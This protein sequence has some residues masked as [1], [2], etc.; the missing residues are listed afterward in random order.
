MKVMALHSLPPVAPANGRHVWEFDLSA[1]A[2][3]IREVMPDAIVA[4]VRGE[5]DEVL[6]VL[7]KDRPDVVFNLCEAPLGRPDREP[8]AAAL[9]EWLGIRFTGSRSETLAL[10]RRKDRVNAALLAAGVPVPRSGVFP[11]IVKPSDEHSSAGLDHDSICEDAA[12]VAAAAARWK[13]PV[14][15]QEFL[16]GREFA[17]A[18]WGRTSPDHFS[19]GETCFQNGLRLNT[20]SAKWDVESQDFADSPLSY[21]TEIAASLRPIILAAAMDAWRAV[22][23]CGYLRVDLRLDDSGAP[24]VIDVNANPELSPEVGMHRA[25]TETGWTWERFVHRQIEWAH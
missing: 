22:G 19:I 24:R 13:G 23:A 20:Y 16:P 25:V 1:A 14:I 7:S 4:G 17:I 5:V 9:L 11:C 6:S 10:C 18:L 15:I 3:G 21:R 12:A 8:H 2:E